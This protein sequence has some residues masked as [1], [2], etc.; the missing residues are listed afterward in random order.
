MLWIRFEVPTTVMMLILVFRTEDG[1]SVFRNVGICVHFQR[2][3]QYCDDWTSWQNCNFKGFARFD[4][5]ICNNMAQEC[6]WLLN[7]P[8]KVNSGLSGLTELALEVY[9]SVLQSKLLFEP[10]CW[11]Q[12]TSMNHLVKSHWNGRSLRKQDRNITFKTKHEL[13]TELNI[14]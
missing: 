8:P 9:I 11:R 5:L 4:L 1:G 3:C 10:R 12:Y 13:T 2:V 7:K 14:V 6:R